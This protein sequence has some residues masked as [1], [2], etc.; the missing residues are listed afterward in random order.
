[1]IDPNLQG[2]V[3]L[4]TGATSGIGHAIARAFDVQGARIAVHY[5]SDPSTPP[6]GV[7]WEH[8]TP[9]ECV[10]KDL[11]ASLTDAAA[12][13]VDLGVDGAP[14]ALLDLV[15]QELGPVD[16][17]INNAAHCEMPD[18]ILNATEA[19]LSRHYRVN[20]IAPVALIGELARRQQGRECSVINISTDSARAFAGQ[21][22]YGTS[23][24]ALEAATRAAAIELGPAHIRVNAV[25]PGPIQTGWMTAEVAQQVE[26]MI[27]LGRVGYPEEVA[28]ACLFLASHQARFITG[29]VLQ[30]AGGHAI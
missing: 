25:A 6:D 26:S 9:P 11:A 2:K 1:M 23:K 30:V 12:V 24:A 14:A 5:L 28:D 3:V 27:P 4:V 7:T 19:G 21:V 22:G 20:A 13:D 29:Q 18:S 8:V 15:E 10:A 16:V 17:L